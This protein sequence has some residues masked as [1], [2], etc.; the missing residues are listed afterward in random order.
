MWLG[1]YDAAAASAAPTYTPM[2][3]IT[4]N[5]PFYAVNVDDLKLGGTSLGYSTAADFQEPIIDT[6]TSLFYLPTAIFKAALKAINASSGMQTLFGGQQLTSMGCVKTPGVTSAMVDA[7][8]P[9]LSLSLPSVTAG[10]PDVTVTAPASLSYLYENGDGEF[11]IAIANGGTSAASTLGLTFL[12]AFVTVIDTEHGR[13]GFAPDTGC[14][15]GGGLRVV[16]PR[17]WPPTS[18]P[19]RVRRP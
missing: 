10:A 1:G 17:P 16:H 6:G 7:D 2:L 13:I 12:R 11:C 4:D 18:R 19:P 8:L 15:A 9:A 14:A 5:D 3:P